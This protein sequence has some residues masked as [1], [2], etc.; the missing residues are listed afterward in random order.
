MRKEVISYLLLGV[1]VFL[2]FIA[3]TALLGGGQDVN[4]TPNR[5]TARAVVATSTPQPELSLQITGTAWWKEEFPT[6]FS[7]A[8]PTRTPTATPTATATRRKP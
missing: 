4:P 8:T 5:A 1:G 6:P 3:F 7:L 2:L